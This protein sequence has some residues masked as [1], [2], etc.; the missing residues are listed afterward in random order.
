LKEVILI[1]NYKDNRL[2]KPDVPSNI[3]E[4]WQ[5]IVNLMAKIVEVPAGLIMKVDP[6]QIEGY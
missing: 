2:K 1:I 6:P 4:K 5:Q 3:Q